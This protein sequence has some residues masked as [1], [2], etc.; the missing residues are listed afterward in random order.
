LI[1]NR[2]TL[3]IPAGRVFSIDEIYES[4]WVEPGYSAENAVAVYIREFE[5]MEINPEKPII[6]W[7]IEIGNHVAHFL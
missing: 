4:V 1:S 2:R 3:D 7:V 5:K 6:I